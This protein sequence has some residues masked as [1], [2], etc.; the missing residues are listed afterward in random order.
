M[1]KKLASFAFLLAV[2]F[3]A[4]GIRPVS[5]ATVS[6]SSLVAGDLIR[7]SATSAVYYYGQDGFRYV[8]PNDKTYFTWYS[9]FDT[10]K[11][12]TDSDLG[13]IQIGGNVTYKPGSQMVKINT[14]P[15]VYVVAKGGKLIAVGSE[16]VASTLYGSAWNTHIDDV[17]DG[18]FS[19]Y[20]VSTSGET[21][22]NSADVTDYQNTL[23]TYDGNNIGDDKS[24]TTFV[25][26]TIDDMMY[27]DEA[28]TIQAGDVVRFVNNDSTKHTATGDDLTWGSGTI[29]ASGGF[30]QKRFNDEGTYT[31]FCSYHPSMTGAIIVE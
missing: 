30:W 28:I 23:I 14:D 22:N 21:L 24:L 27:S 25:T 15:K 11:W 12:L 5:A 20:K 4:V 29:S 7:A 2:I 19:N 26:I 9:N 13:K 31:F 10:V 16:S 1:L 6:L 8:F 17:P 3:G 18:F